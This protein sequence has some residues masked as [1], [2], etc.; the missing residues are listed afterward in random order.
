MRRALL[1]FKQDLRL[2][3][4]PALQSAITA[5]E[6]LALFVLDPDWLSVG[7]LGARQL[8]VHR[9]RFLL[10]SLAALDGE[11]R[12]RGSHLLVLPG[13][14]EQLI[15]DLVARFDLHEVL[16]LDEV[17][18]EARAQLGMLR[19]ALGHV[20]L[21]EFQG[22]Q[23]LRRDDLPCPLEQLPRAY[24]PFRELVEERLPV[25]QP[26]SAPSRLPP[27]PQDSLDLFNPLP[28]L[29]Q[30]G[31]GEPLSEPAGAFPFAGGEVAARAHLRDYLWIGQGVLDYRQSRNSMIGHE[32]SSRLSPW[33]ANGSLSPRRM[34]AELRRHEAQYGRTESTQSLW[35][36]MLR[37]EFFHWSLARRDDLL[38]NSANAL[39]AEQAPRVDQR[40][41]QWTQGRTGMPMVDAGMREL[42]ATGYLSNLSRQL[43]A[44]YLIEELQ[45]DWRYGA[46]WFQE[47][48][49]DY[50][51]ASNWGNW[52]YMEGIAADPRQ[53]QHLNV[54][55]LAR[56]YDPD[57]AYISLWLPELR[58]VPQHLRHAPFLLS[59]L[60]LDALNYPKLEHIPDT[61]RP[62]LPEAA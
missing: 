6:V 61:W 26:R 37:R 30:L 31:M 53:E 35:R 2:D 57:A 22:N 25:F 27:P 58:D 44:S 14:A 16:T 43:V 8:G 7:R 17:A 47:H 41:Q 1:W 56:K 38:F 51:P 15:P 46:A 13:K 20:P 24:S 5:D 9:A 54:L 4:H 40:F 29:S 48:L 42:A 62:Y 60:Q 19:K 50:D 28:T 10:E 55:H 59:H 49:L 32:P 3:D 45:Q 52:A 12:Q 11:L 21:R 18:P 39:A 33:L 36:E 23:L 34:L